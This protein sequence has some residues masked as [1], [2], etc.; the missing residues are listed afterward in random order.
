MVE[1]GYIEFLD[2]NEENDAYIAMNE[3]N[4]CLETTHMEIDPLCILS[5][6]TGIIPYPHH[7]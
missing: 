6:V 5:A 1:K 7:N 3:K 2:V 4:I